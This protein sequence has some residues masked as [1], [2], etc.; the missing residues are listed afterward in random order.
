MKLIA[1]SN[2]SLQLYQVR[3]IKP[4]ALVTH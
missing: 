2:G 3:K 1:H 4:S